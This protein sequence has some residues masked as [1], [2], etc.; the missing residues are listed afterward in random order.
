MKRYS[1]SIFILMSAALI[2]LLPLSASFAGKVHSQISLQFGPL[3]GP[4][5]SHDKPKYH[6]SG[7]YKHHKKYK[8]YGKHHKY[9]HKHRRHYWKHKHYKHG[10]YGG[11]AKKPYYKD[12][13]YGHAYGYG[14]GYDCHKT[15]KI[16]HWHGRKAIIG[17]TLCYNQYGEAYIVPNSHY[18]I[19]YYYY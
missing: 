2:A 17:G 1:R 3:H 15:S 8:Q 16:G 6:A 9:R 12:Y 11:Y 13:S 4:V 7:H 18:L 5:Y 19:E 14:G 10:H